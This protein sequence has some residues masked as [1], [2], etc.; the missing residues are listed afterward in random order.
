MRIEVFPIPIKHLSVGWCLLL[1][2]MLTSAGT[3]SPIDLGPIFLIIVGLALLV[4]ALSIYLTATIFSAWLRLPA[5]LVVLA[6]W[7]F[8]YESKLGAPG[9]AAEAKQSERIKA[10]AQC[11]EDLITLS[12][13]PNG[14]LFE[15][16]GFLDEVAALRTRHI[17]TLFTHKNLKFVE[18]MVQQRPNGKVEIAY[19]NGDGES[20][21]G[22]SLPVGS[23]VRLELSRDGDSRC[24]AETALPYGLKGRFNVPPFLPDTCLAATYSSAPTARYSIAFATPPQGA[25]TGFVNW[26]LTDRKNNTVLASLTD[27]P[28]DPWVSSGSDLSPDQKE[29]N[30]SCGS[31][32]TA[33]VDRLRAVNGAPLHPQLLARTVVVAK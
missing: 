32:H 26:H 21:W 27:V 9:R 13:M 1:S 18:L 30:E 11:K 24:L 4:V 20:G 7:G 5:I 17:L 6:A 3:S 12:Q 25:S 29:I 33:L 14:G 16:D 19:P 22:V 31:R 23:F 15:V 28:P 2:P 8:L 10:N